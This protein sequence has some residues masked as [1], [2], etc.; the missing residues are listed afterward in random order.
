MS[1]PQIKGYTVD[2]VA[3]SRK[4]KLEAEYAHIESKYE[5][6]RNLENKIKAIESE[7]SKLVQRYRIESVD[8]VIDYIRF[9]KITDQRE[10][11][12][13]LC[14]CQNKLNGNIDGIEL[15]LKNHGNEV[16]T[17]ATQI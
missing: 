13:L 6:I 1:K 10:L 14:H 5:E 11:D 2:E 7:C 8:R 16:K 17:D 9:K 3:E 12:T 15:D 4:H